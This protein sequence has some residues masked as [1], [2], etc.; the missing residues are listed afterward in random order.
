MTVQDTPHLMPIFA[1]QPVSQTVASN[2]TAIFSAVAFRVCGMGHTNCPVPDHF[3]EDA[4]PQLI[5]QWLSNGVPILGAVSPTLT[6]SNVQASAVADYTLQI[7]TLWQT[8]VSDDAILQIN[9]TGGGTEVVQAFDKFLDAANSTPLFLG[10]GVPPAQ[11]AGNDGGG[12]AAP[13]A[14]ASVVSGYTGTQ[15][16]ATT[17]SGADSNEV[18][19]GVIGGSSEIIPFIVGQS[20]ILFLNTDGS[21]FNTLLQVFRPSPTNAFVRQIVACGTDDGTPGGKSL[22]LP[23][24]A[25]QTNYILVDGVLGTFGTVSLNYSLETSVALKSMGMS[26]QMINH[27]QVIGRSNVSFSLQVSTNLVTWTTLFNTN[28]PAGVFDFLDNSPTNTP[29]RYYR[30]VVLP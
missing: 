2:T 25:N 8:N 21:S 9:S 23:V 24:T 10:T 11:T 7:S 1:V 6:L 3:P 19:C 30:A 18:V 14:A 13:A 15:I 22:H 29:R 16:F 20:G 27:V 5:Y 12:V 26:G 28:A 17:G 4:L